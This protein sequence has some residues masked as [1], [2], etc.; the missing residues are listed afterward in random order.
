MTTMRVRTEFIKAYQ[1][2]K[3][4]CSE[5]ERVFRLV[6]AYSKGLGIYCLEV[7]TPPFQKAIWR[8]FDA[9]CKT[10]YRLRREADNAGFRLAE[11]AFDIL[12][13]MWCEP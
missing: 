7:D 12:R 1:A 8:R 11:S 13:D 5:R 4:L 6:D 10:Y 2:Y 9:L 3:E